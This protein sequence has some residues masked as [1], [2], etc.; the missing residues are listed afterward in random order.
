MST[1]LPPESRDAGR[2]G[3]LQ[4]Q[5]W[6]ARESRIAPTLLT[7]N[8]HYRYGIGLPAHSMIAAEDNGTVLF[9][10]HP[11]EDREKDEA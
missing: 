1:R 5:T 7:H 4:Q 2:S 10:F 11:A 3:L 8:R 9:C 6:S